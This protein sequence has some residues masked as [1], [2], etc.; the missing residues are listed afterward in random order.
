MGYI[1][2]KGGY[3]IY[4]RGYIIYKRGYIIY[5]MDSTSED[6]LL[7]LLYAFPDFG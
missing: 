2:Y 1:I 6:L 5:E 7:E 4:K 3:I